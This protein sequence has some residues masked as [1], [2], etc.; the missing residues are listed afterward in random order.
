LVNFVPGLACNWA[1]DKV[2]IIPL[3]WDVYN[4]LYR[5]II[6]KI[7]IKK[8][9]QVRLLP[10]FALYC[11]RWNLSNF[12]YAEA[13]S[14]LNFPFSFFLVGIKT[15]FIQTDLFPMLSCRKKFF[16]SLQKEI[17]LALLILLSSRFLFTV[18]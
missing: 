8:Q 4:T 5:K 12:F 18:I 9:P 14:C 13:A 10:C 2:V 16:F 17:I 15:L 3:K 1:W 6:G 7:I 11:V